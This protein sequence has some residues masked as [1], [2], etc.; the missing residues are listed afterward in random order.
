MR[1][2]KFNRKGFTLIEL[3]AV[4]A[5]MAVLMLIASS[6]VTSI[7][8]NSSR[9]AFVIDAQSI[10]ENAKIAYTD[11]LLNGTNTGTHFCMSLDYLKGKYVDKIN[12][13]YQGSVEINVTGG[14]ATYRI[15]LSNGK[16]Q[17][18]GIEYPKIEAETKDYAAAASTTC[19]GNG[20]VVR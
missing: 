1:Q 13:T 18:E 14:V 20:T 7:I 6:S 5:I 15:W 10:V 2:R 19:A 3:L 12:S 9:K 4:I 16:F 17:L 8:A 11:S